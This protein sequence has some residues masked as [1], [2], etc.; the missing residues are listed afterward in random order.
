MPRIKQIIQSSARV[1]AITKVVDLYNQICIKL[2]GPLQQFR[3]SSY[4]NQ[5]NFTGM[6]AHN[7]FIEEL[8]GCG[9]LL[10]KDL[11]DSDKLMV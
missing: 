6:S 11:P 1:D 5:V 2:A 7:I 9:S 3:T 4:R 8:L 10:V